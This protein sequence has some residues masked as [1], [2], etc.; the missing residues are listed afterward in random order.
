MAEQQHT[1][2]GFF[3]AKVIDNKDP[4]MFG[5]VLV[6]I[7]DL[8]PEVPD[9]QGIWALPANNPVGGRN[10]DGDD[11]PYFSGSSFVP[12]KFSFVWIFFEA[13]NPNRP[14]YFGALD[15]ENAK[16]LPECQ[17]GTDYEKKWVL[18]KS[19][20]GRTIVVS[21]DDEDCRVEITGKKRSLAEPPSGD[22]GSVYTI[23]GNQTTIL[24]DEREGKEK[25]LIRTHKGDYFNIDIENQ[26]LQVYFKSDVLIKSDGNIRIDSF[27]DIDIKAAG[28]ANIEGASDVNVKAGEALNL[29]AVGQINEL[30]GATVRIHGTSTSLQSGASPSGSAAN[31]ET[32]GGRDDE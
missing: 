2:Y 26:K 8:M 30:G 32:T 7:P 18:F 16:V 15:L 25:V 12:P 6:W 1:Y 21:D 17:V 14:F 9:D 24:L 11:S 29:Q 23:D 4:E 28:K 31:A 20:N 19:H 10:E 13:G 22:T 3:R 27:S 5:R